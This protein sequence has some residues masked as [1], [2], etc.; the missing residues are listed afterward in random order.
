MVFNI[1]YYMG[2]AITYEYLHNI[3]VIKVRNLYNRC[4]KHQ[5]MIEKMSK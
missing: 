3:N 5:K 4:V 1:A 2:G